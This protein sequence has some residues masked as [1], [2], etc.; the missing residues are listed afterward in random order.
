MKIYDSQTNLYYFKNAGNR[1]N[2]QNVNEQENNRGDNINKT[3][4]AEAIAMAFRGQIVAVI[5][6][7]QDK[8]RSSR[9]PY[10]PIKWQAS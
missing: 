5:K 7:E 3:H 1:K 4:T 8:S 9:P 6:H 2:Y 10:P